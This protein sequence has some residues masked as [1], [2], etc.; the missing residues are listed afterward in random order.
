MCM[1]SFSV[2]IEVTSSR[3][4]SLPSTNRSSDLGKAATGEEMSDFSILVSNC[5][6]FASLSGLCTKGRFRICQLWNIENR[7]LWIF[8]SGGRR[9]RSSAN[10]SLTLFSPNIDSWLLI[11]SRFNTL[12]LALLLTHMIED[13][14]FVFWPLVRFH[15]IV[16]WRKQCDKAGTTEEM[17][18]LKI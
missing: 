3:L 11:L 2:I 16:A 15:R 9:G 8:I 5:A 4:L 14:I 17:L 6:S 1:C 12:C 10:C 13:E 7:Y 18:K